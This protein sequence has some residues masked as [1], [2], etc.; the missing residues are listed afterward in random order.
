MTK[1]RKQNMRSH[2]YADDHEDE[3]SDNKLRKGEKRRPVRNWKKA[4]SDHLDD[5]D[6]VDDFHTR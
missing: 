6:E 1:G 5:Y 2:E 3:Y 4:W